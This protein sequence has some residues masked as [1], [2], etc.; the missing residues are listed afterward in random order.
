[1]LLRW[2]QWRRV[3]HQLHSQNDLLLRSSSKRHLGLTA[4]RIRAAVRD[5]ECELAT[6]S[7]R[8]DNGKSLPR[9]IVARILASIASARLSPSF[10]SAVAN[11]L[12]STMSRSF[13]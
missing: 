4:R 12:L 7:I 6:S 3:R 9:F 1:V 2:S 10:C 5:T 13:S 11:G 8:Q